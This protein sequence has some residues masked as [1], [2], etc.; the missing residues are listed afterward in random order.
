MHAISEQ[1][2]HIVAGDE[3]ESIVAHHEHS[4]DYLLGQGPEQKWGRGIK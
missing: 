4:K 1:C 2:K 3:K